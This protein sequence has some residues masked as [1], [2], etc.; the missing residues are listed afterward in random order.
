[1]EMEQFAKWPGFSF[2][3]KE[4]SKKELNKKGNYYRSRE[5]Q[6]TVERR[7]IGGT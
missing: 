5:R 3:K 7:E 2:D 4:L 1:M 6:I